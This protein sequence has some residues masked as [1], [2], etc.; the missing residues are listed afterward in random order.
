MAEGCPLGDRRHLDFAQRDANDAAEH[1]RGDN[2]FPLDDVLCSSVA[3]DGEQHADFAANTPRRAVAGE[4]IQCS[5]KM[6]RH[7]R[8]GKRIRWCRESGLVGSWLADY[9][10][11]GWS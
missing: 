6:N 9:L 5:E 3:A 4:L 10:L 11:A 7:W 8:R 2:I 1:Q